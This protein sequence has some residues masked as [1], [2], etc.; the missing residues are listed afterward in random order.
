MTADEHEDAYRTW[1]ASLRTLVAD[2]EQLARWQERRF[3][4]AHELGRLLADPYGGA[5]AMSGPVLY[6]VFL[7]G[8]GLCY[9][10][11]TRDAQRR[12]RDLAVGESHHLANT[13]P[14]ELWERVVVV[15]WPDLLASL[16]ARE[17]ETVAALGD[18]VCGLALEHLLHVTFAPPL[19]SRRR[20]RDGVWRPRN[21]ADSRS[22]GAVHASDLAELWQVVQAAWHS[23][24]A[25]P[26]PAGGESVISTAV[27]RAVFPGMPGP[28]PV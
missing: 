7:S 21:H 14:P 25:C 11:Q 12:L 28:L 10:G 17:R 9:V 8:A 6:G 16:P 18:E 23:L 3:R 22:R 20:H 1:R 19:N 24:A 2:A 15:R 13:V 5:P 4:F 26:V 27:G